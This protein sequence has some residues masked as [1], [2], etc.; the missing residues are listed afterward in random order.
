MLFK[1]VYVS[2]ICVNIFV[3][4]EYNR[5]CLVIY[6][7]SSF[8]GV[9]KIRVSLRIFFIFVLNILSLLR[10]GDGYPSVR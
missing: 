5:F 2:N 6:S 7:I 9:Y 4:F 1:Y 3:I 10:I 8:V